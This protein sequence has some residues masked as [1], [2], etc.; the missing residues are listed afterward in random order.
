LSWFRSIDLLACIGRTID[1]SRL[2]SNQSRQ[3][4][5]AR[6]LA[7][8]CIFE[9]ARVHFVW[10]ALG[11]T[12]RSMQ[13]CDWICSHFL[14][15]VLPRA[16]GFRF[17]EQESAKRTQAHTLDTRLRRTSLH[18]VLERDSCIVDSYVHILCHF[19]GNTAGFF[20]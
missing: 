19:V 9:A 11:C 6:W 17:R 8:G 20:Y 2:N 12:I 16:W 15:G 10:R 14:L 13:V 1:W 4:V 7:C 18:T 5:R 3:S